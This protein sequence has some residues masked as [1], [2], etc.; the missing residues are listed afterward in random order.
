MS[1]VSFVY[2][3]NS[4]GLLFLLS[5][6]TLST[7]QSL[8]NMS[9]KPMF[10]KPARVL[11]LVT[12]EFHPINQY[13]HDWLINK[14][15]ELNLFG[16]FVTKKD[17]SWVHATTEAARSVASGQ[18]D[19]GIFFCWSGTG[20]CMTANKVKGIKAALCT[21][22]ETV[23]LARVWNHANVL[24]LSNRLLTPELADSMLLAWFDGSLDVAEGATGVNELK[25]LENDE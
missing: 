12:D 4:I 2:L 13:V 11:A 16:S 17:E 20:S 18:S 21:D 9:T 23:K 24:V 7:S 19:E 22:A 8:N 10:L 1:S 6:L 3:S 15:Y 14:G 5:F 25:G